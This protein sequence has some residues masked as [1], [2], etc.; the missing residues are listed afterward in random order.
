MCRKEVQN[1]GIQTWGFERSIWNTSAFRASIYDL[2][3]GKSIR[4]IWPHYYAEVK[5]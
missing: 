4:G 2:G 1:N 5:N 3:G